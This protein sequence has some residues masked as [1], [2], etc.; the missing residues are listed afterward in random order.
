MSPRFF[1]YR[2]G[3][4]YLKIHI[5]TTRGACCAE[6]GIILNPYRPDLGNTSEGK[7]NNE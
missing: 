2:N 6:R 3:A 5:E 4:F 1:A 7:W